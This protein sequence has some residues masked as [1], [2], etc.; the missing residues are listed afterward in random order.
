MK[1]L[2][3][4][5]L[6]LIM[7]LSLNVAGLAE[8]E[9][10][11]APSLVEACLVTEVLD[12]GETLTAIRIEYSEEI[13]CDAFDITVD[14]FS[15]RS[16]RN[17]VYAY[18]NNTGK[19]GDMEP[20]GKYVFLK[21]DVVTSDGNR[22]LEQ[23]AFNEANSSR[24]KLNNVAVYQHKDLVTC[25]GNVIPAGSV[26]ASKEIRIGVDDF[27][28]VYYTTVDDIDFYY[29]IF[30]P[31]GYEEKSDALENLPL[32]VHFPSGDYACID[33]NGIYNGALYRHPDATVWASDAVQAKHPS[34]V[35][36][37]GASSRIP[38]TMYGTF[39][40]IWAAGVYVEVVQKLIEEYNIDPNRVYAISLAG[41]TTMMWN[42][43]M[44]YP[45][46]FAASMSTAFDFYMSYPDPDVA[47]ENLKAVLDAVPCWF[48]AGMKDS[49]GS[50]PFGL[51]RLKGERLRD[52]AFLANEAGYHVDVAWG[53]NGELMW[54]GVIRGAEA[55][56]MAQ[57]Q[58]DRAA[59]NGD[60][61]FVTLFYPNTLLTSQHWSWSAAYTNTA[62]QDWLYA[63]SR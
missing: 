4:L 30:V 27:E 55:A 28:S 40:E 43:I 26:N 57:A 8:A 56:A 20:F 10:E 25:A 62:V 38:N 50:D 60:T 14:D 21:L 47:F 34:F 51:G 7:A 22:Y 31:E 63:Q 35:V 58:I 33:Y 2:L 19:L 17:I 24:P 12:W 53:E 46:L 39:D 61:S 6:A 9:E 16:L 37:I 48:F 49:T 52:I 44:R 11:A 29:N 54:N 5:L 23:V 1:K 18:V 13:P 41:G 42:T 15:I 32:V 3:V 59:A 45:E 36:T